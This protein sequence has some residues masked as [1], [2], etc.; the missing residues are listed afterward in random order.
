MIFG[1]GQVFGSGGNTGFNLEA[2]YDNL[3]IGINNSVPEPSSLLMLVVGLALLS[4]PV[5]ASRRR[6]RY[7]LSYSASH[8]RNQPEAPFPQTADSSF[9]L[10]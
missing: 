9:C 10:P 2:D 1:L 3:H 7:E 6:S 4:G 8:M 5:L